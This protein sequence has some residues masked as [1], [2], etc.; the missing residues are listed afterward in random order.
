M[1]DF[2]KPKSEKGITEKRVTRRQE[3]TGH[4]AL[5][6]G[7][8]TTAHS[9]PHTR[10]KCVA[11]KMRICEQD[12]NSTATIKLFLKFKTKSFCGCIHA[13]P[14]IW[15][16]AVKLFNYPDI[17]KHTN[18]FFPILSI[19]ARCVSSV[20]S[21]CHLGFSSENERRLPKGYPS[22]E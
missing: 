10:S 5:H 4:T 12:S 7:G 3:A 17:L 19:Q 13:P 6:A 15:K 18:P 1:K 14:T 9:F 16:G 21:V 20:E 22:P 2:V 11:V 8:K